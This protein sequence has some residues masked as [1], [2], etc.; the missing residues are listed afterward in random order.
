V[1][2]VRLDREDVLREF[3]SAERRHAVSDL[4]PSDAELIERRAVDDKSCV[5]GQ[6][7]AFV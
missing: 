3:M 4:V 5:V 6:P 2:E 7:D 1:D